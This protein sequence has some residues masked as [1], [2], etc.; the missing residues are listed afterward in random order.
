ML[1]DSTLWPLF[2]Y[3]PGEIDFNEAHWDGYHQ[4]NAAFA[5]ALKDQVRE[6]D[7]IWV[8]DYHLM[9]LPAMLRELL[10]GVANVRI[11]FFLH[12]PFPSSEVY[13]VLPVRKEV[14]LGIL[15]CDL[16]GFHTYDY[17][18]H[19]LSSCGRILAISTM[20]NG[21]EFDGR[22][23]HVG[24]F[25]IGIDPDKFITALDN[26]AVQAKVREL[27]ER[28]AGKK[29]MVGV[30][31]LD[32]IKGVPHKL[33]AFDQFLT[34]Y[35]EWQGK[36]ALLQVA[37]P[38]RTEVEEYKNLR[39]SVNEL[40]GRINGKFGSFEFTPVQYLYRSV[41]FEELVALYRVA[42][43]CVVTS[44][45]DGMNLVHKSKIIDHTYAC[46]CHMSLW[47]RKRKRAEC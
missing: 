15:K 29:L 8:E 9:L 37:V 21:A 45:R 27:E 4:A 20:P 18:R 12:T 3:L 28:F 24:T 47:L 30:D 23:V 33:H 6:G 31:R 17:A 10:L 36:V 32:Y 38:T 35:P 44:T 22:F 5:A 1:F 2:H 40:V 7:L 19:F 46:R 11:G 26:P 25:P 42:D 14:L 13:R 43:V 41:S 34:R 39:T 16:I